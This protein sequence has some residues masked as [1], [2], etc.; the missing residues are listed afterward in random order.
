MPSAAWKKLG[1]LPV[2]KGKEDEDIQT[3]LTVDKVVTY[4]TGRA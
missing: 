3:T 4:I 1:N 2:T